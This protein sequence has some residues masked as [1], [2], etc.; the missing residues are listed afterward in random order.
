MHEFHIIGILVEMSPDQ[1]SARFQ[2]IVGISLN[3]Q[4]EAQAVEHE[5]SQAVS[6]ASKAS[7]LADMVSVADSAAWD[8][9]FSDS[10]GHDL[11]SLIAEIALSRKDI[12]TRLKSFDRYFA[13][14]KRSVRAVRPDIADRHGSRS[15]RRLKQHFG[16]HSISARALINSLSVRGGR[17][18]PARISQVAPTQLAWPEIDVLARY[19][20]GGE[21]QR[22]IAESAGLT[23]SA[24]S[25]LIT[26]TIH[27]VRWE[28]DIEEIA[29]IVLPFGARTSSDP[30]W[31]VLSVDFGTDE[32]LALHL[33]AMETGI[34]VD[35]LRMG[36]ITESENDRIKPAIDTLT[37]TEKTPIDYGFNP[38][39]VG[40]PGQYSTDRA[41]L[42]VI[43]DQA[44]VAI[45]LR[46]ARTLSDLLIG[47]DRVDIRRH[48]Q[49]KGQFV[50]SL[51][52]KDLNVAHDY[53]EDFQWHPDAES[54]EI[55]DAFGNT[56]TIRLVYYQLVY[57]HNGIS[58][59]HSRLRGPDTLE[60]FG[61][62]MKLP[63]DEAR[64]IIAGHLRGAPYDPKPVGGNN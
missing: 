35:R 16:Q 62:G 52:L 25:H 23:Q 48:V 57:W 53:I 44:D 39:T 10:V 13:E 12:Q 8:A 49:G 45:G 9:D 21:T 11:H 3:M 28:L 41:A 40:G 14:F 63:L 51:D 4:A 5:G 22:E 50:Y 20:L 26:R 38:F 2:Q 37:N 59:I 19:F 60:A 56:R 55:K 54:A 18:D 17:L 30:P 43:S 29:R 7:A 24:I 34:N 31:N 42:W 61:R 32:T 64:E 36:L 15:D 27:I 6:K 33:L 46:A 58:T 1:K 47:E